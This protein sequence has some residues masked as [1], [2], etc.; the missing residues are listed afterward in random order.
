LKVPEVGFLVDSFL[1]DPAIHLP[2]RSVF[3]ADLEDIDR[4]SPTLARAIMGHVLRE[5]F[6]ASRPP[7]QQPGSAIKVYHVPAILTEAQIAGD[8]LNRPVWTGHT[9]P[10]EDWY[11]NIMVRSYGPSM[12]FQL[13]FNGGRL[14]SVREP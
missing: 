6:G 12:K 5:Y 3:V 10:W 1:G 7:G 8:L 13:F 2:R 11:G 4:M 9:R 14:R